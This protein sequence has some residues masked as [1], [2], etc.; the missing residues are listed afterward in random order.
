[1]KS[2]LPSIFCRESWFRSG[3][4]HMSNGSLGLNPLTDNDQKVLGA[5]VT[6]VGPGAEPPIIAVHVH[7]SSV[8]RPGSCE[9]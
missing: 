3:V 9:G 6:Q 4:I 7:R 2:Q 8:P 5:S 1:M